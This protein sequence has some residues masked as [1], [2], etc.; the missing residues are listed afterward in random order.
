MTDSS[1]T[2]TKNPSLSPDE[3]SSQQRATSKLPRV[4]PALEGWL[5]EKLADLFNSPEQR[6]DGYTLAPLQTEASFRQFYRVTGVGQP[7]VLMESPPDK[8]NNQQFVA[9]ARAFRTGDICVPEVHAHN[10]REGWLLLSDLGDTHFIDAYRAGGDNELRCMHA[11]LETLDKIAAVTDPT[12]PPYTTQ[13]LSDE[14]DIFIDWLAAD[15]CKIA[16]P[17]RLF[18]PVRKLLL[19]TASQQPQVCVHR[20]FHCK[21]LLVLE[22]GSDATGPDS[23]GVGVLDFQDALIGPLGYDHAS[24]LHD[25]YWKF[26]DA[27]I[28]HVVERVSGI[29]R[30][31]V[32]L[33]AVQRQLK[34][35]GIFAR[36]ASRDGKTSHLPYI[37]PVLRNIIYLCSRYPEL[38]ALG[39]WLSDSLSDRALYWVA[40][41]RF[42][43]MQTK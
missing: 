3:P 14:L 15:A 5:Q 40:A 41:T 26:P 12:I 29:D 36:L 30:R 23:P 31:T 6:S 9:V 38:N 28:D 20:D 24:L 2:K 1:K 27:I 7:L 32:D 19:D 39:H 13:R 37:E 34:A 8:E 35:I 25:C 10:E 43:A 42:E 21:N 11:A 4:S 33:L 22:A 16:P 17:Q 18:E